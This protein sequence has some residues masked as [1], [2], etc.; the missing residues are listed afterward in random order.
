MT[1]GKVATPELD[2]LDESLRVIIKALLQQD[3]GPEEVATT[4]RQHLGHRVGEIVHE[5]AG[6]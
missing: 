5:E 6:S 1:T 2:A 3:N 4:L